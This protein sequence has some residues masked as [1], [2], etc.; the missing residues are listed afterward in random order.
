MNLQDTMKE[1]RKTLSL[2]QNDLAEMS[3]LGLATIKDIERGK[4][5][6]SM[7]TVSKIMDVL[8]ME[9]IYRVRNT[10]AE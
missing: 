10:V 4:G 8:G 1:R 3:E 9:I 7:A 6:P 2:S 5:N